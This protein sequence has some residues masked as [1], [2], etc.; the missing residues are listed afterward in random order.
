MSYQEEY[1]RS[2]E[3]PEDF[4]R[5]QAKELEW[6]EFPQSILS[7]DEKGFYRWFQG[8]K[9]NTCHLAVDYHVNQGRGEQA[10]LIYDSPVTET[11]RTVTYAE[12]LKEVSTFA[13]VLKA[14]GVEKGDR[15]IIYMPMMVEAVVAMLACARIGAI[16]SVVFG[17]FAPNEL[18]VRIDDAQPKLLV[19]ASCG[20]EVNRVIEYKPLVDKALELA[21]NPPE[22]VVLLQ[23]PQAE[24]SMQPGRDV[25]WEEAVSSA[26]PADAVPVEATDPLYV[27]YTS[28]TT[29]LPKGVIRDNGG[30]AVALKYSMKTVYNTNP[31]EVF[32]AA[33]DVGWVVGHS[34]IVYAPLLQGCT[35]IVYEGN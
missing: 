1:R 13:G 28:G 9:L 17:G 10:A 3:Q 21:K 29:G 32:W 35:T 12:L 8:G 6:F 22:R 5:E 4:W 25:D 23:R 33:S 7:Q 26:T 18:A 2:L 14:Q 31:G 34:Y 16:H 11:K 20:I 15:V 19:T 30:H 27:L 24:A